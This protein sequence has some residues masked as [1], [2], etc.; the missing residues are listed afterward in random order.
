MVIILAYI[1]KNIEE[2]FPEEDALKCLR[3]FFMLRFVNVFIAMPDR[4][5]VI[6][7]TGQQMKH[8]QQIWNMCWGMKDN[9]QFACSP[10]AISTLSRRNL[11]LLAKTLQGMASG[12]ISKFD[13]GRVCFLC[14][15]Y[16]RYHKERGGGWQRALR[17]YCYCTP[18]MWGK[19]TTKSL[20][21][22]S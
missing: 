1:K 7:T 13:D 12:S 8:D 4:H 3:I 21:H 18:A 19:G 5:G 15:Y 9:H 14:H 22:N 10:T 17:H 6:D 11:A 2:K 16:V 20:L